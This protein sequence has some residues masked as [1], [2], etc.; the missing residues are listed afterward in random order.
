M[1]VALAGC[2]TDDIILRVEDLERQVIGL[3]DRIEDLEAAQTAEKNARDNSAPAPCVNRGTFQGRIESLLT[4]RGALLIK[5]T[6]QHPDIVE[7]DRQ[8]RLA[9]DQIRMLDT[10][11]TTCDGTSST[12]Q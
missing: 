7:L 9:Q 1:V 5:Y 10:A 3:E 2:V 8:I 4:K 11:G 6:D 12:Q